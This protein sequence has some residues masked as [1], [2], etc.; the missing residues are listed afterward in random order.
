M[1]LK[2][3]YNILGAFRRSGLYP[4]TPVIEG[5]G[6]LP[7]VKINGQTFIMFSSNNYI[8]L[9]NNPYVIQKAEE[10]LRIH[11]LG[12]GGSRF[13]CG[14]VDIINTLEKKLAAFVGVEDTITFPTGYMA[15]TAVFSAVM[16]PFW[17]KGFGAKSDG[18][19]ISDENNH[20]TIVDGCRLSSAKKVT[21]R[22][23]DIDDLV[24]KIIENERFEKKLIVTESVYSTEGLLV[25]INKVVEIAKEYKSLLMIDDAHGIGV[26]GENGGGVISHFG[27][28]SQPD[29]LMAS[30][31]KALGTTGGFLGGKRDLIDYLRISTRP[32]LFSSSI[33]AVVAAGTIGAVEFLEDN[34]TLLKRL[35]SNVEIVCRGLEE[36]GL[37][38][39]GKH[40]T[41]A[42]P[43]FIGD[44]AKGMQFSNGL[45][46]EKVYAPCFRYPAVP[47][48]KSR[49]RISVMASHAN[50]DI[51]TLIQACKKVGKKL[52]LI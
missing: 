26:L 46:E 21:Y 38:V 52:G 24:T 10:A 20:A 18:V 6:T 25:D 42:V 2:S 50:T 7:N 51:E 31:D 37:T 48:G 11:G 35:R 5:S 12:P 40:K 19:I 39:L 16:D 30:L 27:L 8:G 44:D 41:P 45:F 28:K 9:A 15:N 32:Y 4:N 49:I 34:P 22:H 43:L 33:P 13:L 1:P 3:L 17:I 36:L 14:N 23:N 47:S 29:I